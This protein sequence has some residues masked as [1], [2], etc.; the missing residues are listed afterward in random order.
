M[1]KKN[2]GLELLEDQPA[3]ISKQNLCKSI[4][5]SAVRIVESLLSNQV[6]ADKRVTLH[7]YHA[8]TCI[9]IHIAI[10]RY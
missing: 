8:F 7:C 10:R 5:L 4:T 3:I 2:K 6:E 1:E 9:H